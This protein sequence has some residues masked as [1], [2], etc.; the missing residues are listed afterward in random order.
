MSVLAGWGYR[1]K[2]AVDHTLVSS[3]ITDFPNHIRISAASGKNARNMQDV[4][5]KLGNNSKKIAVTLSDGV[6]QCFVEV[7]FWDSAQG[8]AE[9]WVRVPSVSQSVDTNL[10]LYYDPAHA[11]NLTYVGTPIDPVVAR[12]RD[13][14]SFN[15]YLMGI[16][17]E[18]R[19]D[20]TPRTDAWILANNYS[21]IDRLMTYGAPEVLGS[22]SD[23]TIAPSG[24]NYVVKNSAGTQILGP[25]TDLGTLLIGLNNYTATNKVIAFTAGTFNLRTVFNWTKANTTFQLSP[26]TVILYGPGISTDLFNVNGS[27]VAWD[28]AVN[29]TLNANNNVNLQESFLIGGTGNIL[30]NLKILNSIQYAVE[31]WRAHSGKFLNCF[32][33][34]AQ[35]G[36]ASG[37][38]PSGSTT[39]QILANMNTDVEYAGLQVR[40]FSD[41]GLKLRAI[42]GGAAHDNDID[43]AWITKTR[44]ASGG[45]SN[46]GLRFYSADAPNINMTADHNN[47]YDSKRTRDTVGIMVDADQTSGLW[48]PTGI[49]SSGHLITRNTM[50]DL[51]DGIILKFSGVKIGVDAAGNPAGNVFRTLRRSAIHTWPGVTGTVVKYC[52][53]RN[54]GPTALLEEGSG[55]VMQGSIY[56]A[57][58]ANTVK[59][60]TSSNVSGGSLIIQGFPTTP[61]EVLYADRAGTLYVGATP[62]PGYNLDHFIVNGASQAPNAYGIVAIGLGSTDLTIQAV[63][64]PTAFTLTYEGS[65]PPVNATINGASVAPGGT[66][67][68]PAGSTATIS[69]PSQESE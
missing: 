6:T 40:D 22:V 57:L 41:C 11:D 5:T 49:K 14:L 63:Y 43:C 56:N 37:A 1:F 16:L 17:D 66:V 58:A 38:D 2:M 8:L 34:G 21:L 18:V 64:S 20:G 67:K 42:N 7:E 24:S 28:G 60:S 33:S 15:S 61:N 12:A 9:L 26:A 50:A 51:Y 52:D 54:C 39:A 55:T 53:F 19:V 35:Y 48:A 32:L 68:V 44:N 62:I 31:F 46:T 23:Y 59:V 27:N 3:S 25:Y 10:Y 29:G 36:F 45:T 4:F 47:I 13:S 30:K 65:Q 69:V